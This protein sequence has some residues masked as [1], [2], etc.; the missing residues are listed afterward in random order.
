MEILLRDR[1]TNQPRSV[2][3][4]RGTIV[5]RTMW[6]AGIAKEACDTGYHYVEHNWADDGHTAGLPG[7]VRD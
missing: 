4:G 3:S 7:A 1:T 5:Y 2:Y 6:V